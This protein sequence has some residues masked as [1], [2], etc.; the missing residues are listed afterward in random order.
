VTHGTRLTSS[1]SLEVSSTLFLNSSWWAILCLLFPVTAL[2]LCMFNIYIDYKTQT[3]NDRFP[4]KDAFWVWSKESGNDGWREHSYDDGVMWRG[5]GTY[6]LTGSLSVLGLICCDFV[7]FLL[8]VSSMVIN[9]MQSMARLWHVEWD[10][11]LDSLTQL[12]FALRTGKDCGDGTCTFASGHPNCTDNIYT[13]S[14]ICLKHICFP[15]HITVSNPRVG[16]W[17]CT[18]P[19]LWYTLTCYGAL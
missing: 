18:A 19:L 11:T 1:L 15:C 4:G 16:V 8:F 13:V 3:V 12:Y 14:R 9:S 6:T 7:C 2:C 10:V 5:D 17:R